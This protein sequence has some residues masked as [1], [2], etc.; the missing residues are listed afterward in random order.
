MKLFPLLQTTLPQSWVEIENVLPTLREEMK[1]TSRAQYLT[2]KELEDRLCDHLQ[3]FKE[4]AN[5]KHILHAV[6]RY[7]VKLGKI[8]Y[9]E[10]V[11]QLKDLIFPD[12]Q[13][14]IMLVKEV[15]HHDLQSHLQFK[16][17]FRACN[18]NVEEFDDEKRE[19]VEK[20]LLSESLLRCIWFDAVPEASDFKKL[21]ALLYHFDVGYKMTVKEA[22]FEGKEIN[23]N[24]TLIP[25][26]MAATRPPSIDDLWPI[27]LSADQMERSCEYQFYS[28]VPVGLFERQ[29]VRSHQCSDYRIHWKEGFVGINSE[30]QDE[31]KFCVIKQNK[32]VKLT[33]RINKSGQINTL[34]KLV[35]SL[36]QTFVD[37]VQELWP[38]LRYGIYNKCP[39]CN[40]CHYKI[41]FERL[42]KY[43][44]SYRHLPRCEKSGQ[45]PS[46]KVNSKLVIPPPGISYSI[47]NFLYDYQCK[48]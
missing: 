12:P 26:L 17:E 35:L 2:F 25:A 33:A 19:L 47:V 18:M 16:K 11:E 5:R 42:L 14:L 46:I 6:L 8:L 31:V 48:Y 41:D 24:Y 29:M 39:K 32:K 37:M 7:L 4:D 22:Q 38:E 40:K 3:K 34:W 13:W 9:F 1:S 10:H 21:V 36:H 15:V 28:T 45:I 20:G 23:K 27:A 44:H 43:P 30:E